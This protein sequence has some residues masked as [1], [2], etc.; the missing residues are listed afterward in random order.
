[1]IEKKNS[2]VNPNNALDI[3]K[4]VML[5]DGFEIVLDLEKSSGLTIVDKRNGDK[6]LDFYSFFAS[7][8]LGMNH[9]K[10]NTK[11]FKEELTLAA[12]N[13]PSN[14]DIYTLEMAKF[15]DTLCRLAMPQYFKHL[16]F[17]EGGTLGV[18]NGLK[19]AFDW[20]VKKNFMKGYKEEK[21]QQVIHF[22]QAFHGR[23]GYTL[24]LTNT[25]PVKTAHYPKFNWPRITNP[26]IIFPI[27]ENLEK[28]QQM[29]AQA[30]NEIYSAIKN[31]KDDIAAIIIEPIQ[32]E[33]GDNHF[34]KEF[35]Q[36]LREIADEEE[37]MLIIDEVQTGVGLTGK[38]W[39]HEYFVKPDIMAFGK[40]LQVCGI[41]VG[42]RIDEVED[43]VL[44]VSGRINST[45]GGNLTDMV[46]ARKYL[47]IIIEDNLIENARVV[48]KYLLEKLLEVQK[49]FPQLVQQARGLGLMCAFDMPNPEIR[50]KFLTRLFE[51]K[52]LMLGCGVSTIRFRPPL[53]I[54]KEE[55][56]KGIEIIRKTLK[57]L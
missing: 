54:S 48:G 14:S 6:Y 41:M 16:F 30:I 7:S 4:K 57:S 43:N 10:L 47:E 8:P 37:I 55:V 35:F 12:M 1:M 42:E 34:R 20:K 44:K 39:A 25:D 28:I 11:E 51:N 19:A 32:G 53:I 46:R 40:K 17:V 38:M 56:D 18:E 22:R 23:S 3:L 24:S 9:P 52:M 26:K 31:N 29:E 13:K 15:V 21:G 27:E 45:W 49:D 50:K 36:K 2:S 5:I 33:G